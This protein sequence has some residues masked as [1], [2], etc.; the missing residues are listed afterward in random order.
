[1]MP[2]VGF[3]VVAN[4]C[5]FSNDLLF[6]HFKYHSGYLSKAAEEAERGEH[7]NNAEEYKRYAQEST[8]CFF[9]AEV[10]LPWYE[11]D[12]VQR[13]LEAWS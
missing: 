5:L 13:L 3:H 11:C 6:A 8:C 1:M 10:S 4:V 9:D 2:G 12:F 7:Y